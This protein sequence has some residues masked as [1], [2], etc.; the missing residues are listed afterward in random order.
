MRQYRI[1]GSKPV[2]G[3]AYIG[4]AKN[5]ALPL[6]AAICLNKGES[7]IHNCPRI[8][9]TL[10]TVEILKHV[11][12][13]ADFN[14]NTLWVDTSGISEI[15]I[16]G[17][18]VGKMRSS[19]LFMG[20]MLGR[21][22]QVNIAQPGGCEIGERGIGYHLDGLAAMGATIKLE[23]K[24]FHCSGALRGADIHFPT[25]SVGATQNIMLAATLAKGRTTISNAAKEPEVVD[26][27]QLL[28][29]MGA[30]IRGAGTEKIIIEG[31]NRLDGTTHKVRPDR[32]VAGTYLVAAAMTQGEIN[33]ANVYPQDL[34]NVTV[35]LTE[36]G[37]KVSHGADNI[38][39]KGPRRLKPLPYLE[40]AEHPGF[41]TDMQA[42]FVAALSVADGHSIVK[43]RIFDNRHSHAAQ[44]RLMGAGVESRQVSISDKKEIT[45]FEIEGRPG[46]HGAVVTAKD[47]RCGA[48]LVLAGLAAEGETVVKNAKYVER[49]YERIED[50]LAGVGVDILVE[51]VADEPNIDKATAT[52]TVA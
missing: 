21:V 20:A 34:A 27:A 5:A 22:G 19:L 35:K 30:D 10:L 17:K 18:W 41:P 32:I 8:A 16:P 25:A 50:T 46:L 51:E 33:V 52:N 40:T 37:C 26:L 12:C 28:V 11:G 47:L 44:L 43:E 48:A 7:V 4:G 38:T 36:M 31:V 42:Q 45:V 29:R 1:W 2:M 6:L 23:D 49:G 13:R 24:I 9:D 39:L 3:Q 15:N 14:G